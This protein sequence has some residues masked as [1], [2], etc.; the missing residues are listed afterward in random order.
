[1]KI[2][3]YGHSSLE[4]ECNGKILIVDPFIQANPQAAS[5]DFSSI[6]ADY[7]LITHAHYD[8]VMDVEE[9]AKRTGAKIIANHEIVTY[10]SNRGFEG[11]GM[12]CGG[13]WQFDFGRVKM[14]QAIHSSS[15][16][17]G[18]YGGTAAGFVIESKGKTI[19]IAG[20]TALHLD[21]QLIPLFFKLDLAI[22]P[23]GGNFTM[24]VTEAIVASEYLKCNNILGVH[25]NT[26][27]A[28]TINMEQAKIDFQKQGKEL[29]LLNIGSQ[30]T[31]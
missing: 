11:H 5:I 20:D 10:Y 25:Y 23:I 24:D 17:D 15:F 21:M 28:I 3:Y 12:N 22:L 13:S 14:V 29:T 1:M 9:L 26:A 27:E 19:Y 8:H 16:P 30:I 18:T 7:I 4:I 6:K 2:I 31:I